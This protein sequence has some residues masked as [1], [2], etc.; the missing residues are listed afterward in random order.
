MS[1][2]G[3]EA[4]AQPRLTPTGPGTSKSGAGAAV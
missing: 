4:A 2:S 1:G 3:P